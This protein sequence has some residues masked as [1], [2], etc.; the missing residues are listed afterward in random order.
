[1]GKK[2]FDSI[3]ALKAFVGAPQ[4]TGDAITVDQETID[5]FAGVTQDRQ[6]IHTDPQRAAS[7]SPFNSTI[8]HRLLTLSL[9]P[10][11]YHRCLA[12]P[13]RKMPLNYGFDKIRFPAPVPRDS[14]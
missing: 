1:M 8:A 2:S 13:N 11:W 3:Q 5:V 14:R 12:L 7:E 10:G 9:I 4:V 6:W